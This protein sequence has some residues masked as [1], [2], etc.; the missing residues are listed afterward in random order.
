MAATNEVSEMQMAGA[1]RADG[2]LQAW[3][4]PPIN[5]GKSPGANDALCKG[6]RRSI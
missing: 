4:S 5:A 2:S 3:H 6:S 1:A